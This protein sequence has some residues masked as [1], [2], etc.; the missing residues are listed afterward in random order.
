MAAPLDGSEEWRLARIPD[1]AA[2]VLP[3]AALVRLA[4]LQSAGRAGGLP[5][6]A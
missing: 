5:L 2:T 3:N 6:L 4:V 1:L